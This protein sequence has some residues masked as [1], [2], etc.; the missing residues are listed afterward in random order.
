MRNIVVISTMLVLLALPCSNIPATP[1]QPTQALETPIATW[2]PA[3][4]TWATPDD[5]FGEEKLI[6]PVRYFQ[7]PQYPT[8]DLLD[9]KKYV[10]LTKQPNG[11]Y[12]GTIADIVFMLEWSWK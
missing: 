12:Y 10:T 8:L 7:G 4:T 2:K 6:L 9:P 11:R 5:E 1:E 3:F